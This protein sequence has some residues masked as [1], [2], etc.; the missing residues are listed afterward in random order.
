MP[1]RKNHLEVLRDLGVVI[2]PHARHGGRVSYEGPD[3]AVKPPLAAAVQLLDR[4]RNDIPDFASV[5][6]EL[7]GK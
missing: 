7:Y 2:V 4:G 1:L 6:S 5:V 3:D